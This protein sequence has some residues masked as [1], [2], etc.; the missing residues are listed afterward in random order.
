MDNWKIFKGDRTPKPDWK[1]PPSPS[2]R[3]FGHQIEDRGAKF[4]VQP[5]AIERVN[6]ALYLRR[7]LLVTGKPGTG[8]TSLA[9]AVA[10]ELQLGEV[11]VW[12]IKQ[13]CRKT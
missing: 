13:L 8:K 10:H 1:L 3:R 12:P 2:W 7:P 4:Q 6:A 9:Y 5:D 11:L